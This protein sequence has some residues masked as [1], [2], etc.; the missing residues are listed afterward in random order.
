MVLLNVPIKPKSCGA[1]LGLD[2]CTVPVHCISKHNAM[3]KHRVFYSGPIARLTKL[4]HNE[5]SHSDAY[6]ESID[7]LA[8]SIHYS[9]GKVTDDHQFTDQQLSFLIK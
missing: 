1:C 7:L 5:I 8:I 3:I 2:Q 9:T 4:L 6:T